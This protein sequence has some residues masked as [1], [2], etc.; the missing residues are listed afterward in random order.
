MDQNLF[1]L[2]V[3]RQFNRLLSDLA[4]S[5]DIAPFLKEVISTVERFLPGCKVSILTLNKK[6]LNTSQWC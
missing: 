1:L 6:T 5:S 2:T 3:H 4:L